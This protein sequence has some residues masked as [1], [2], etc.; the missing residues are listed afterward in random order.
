M[1]NLLTYG[2]GLC[3]GTQLYHQ[4]SLIK[5]LVTALLFGIVYSQFGMYDIISESMLLAFLCCAFIQIM[6][7]VFDFFIGKQM[8]KVRSYYKKLNAQNRETVNILFPMLPLGNSSALIH[9]LFTLLI[10]FV[11]VMITCFWGDFIDESSS[12]FIVLTGCMALIIGTLSF[13]F[14]YYPGFFNYFKKSGTLE[15]R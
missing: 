9:L 10:C 15:A 4:C 12:G 8:R 11:S 5:V 3:L 14:L 1:G 2:E 6:A 7:L 13:F